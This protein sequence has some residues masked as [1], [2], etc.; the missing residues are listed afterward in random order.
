MKRVI[1]TV[2]VA[3]LIP[4]QS[5]AAIVIFITSI[6]LRI[7]KVISESFADAKDIFCMGPS[8]RSM[9]VLIWKYKGKE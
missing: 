3:L 7:P 5:M 9:F 4:I 1:L 2:L 8:F 6:G